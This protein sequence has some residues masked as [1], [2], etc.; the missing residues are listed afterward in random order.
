[1][2]LDLLALAT[3]TIILLFVALAIFGHLAIRSRNIRN[4]QFQIAMIILV[5]ITSEIVGNLIE[6]SVLDTSTP[7]DFG[8]WIHLTAMTAISVTFWLRFYYSKR[9]GRRFIDDVSR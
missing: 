7:K 4:F 1:M 2:T 8:L 6:R 3:P 9:A 5:W